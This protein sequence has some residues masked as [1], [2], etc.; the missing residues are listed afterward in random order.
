MIAVR[1]VADLA[2][3]PQGD[4]LPGSD[5]AGPIGCVIVVW[6][7]IW[8][9]ERIIGAWGAKAVDRL[10]RFVALSIGLHVFLA[11]FTYKLWDDYIRSRARSLDR[12]RYTDLV[13][14][15]AS[16]QRA[17]VAG[18]SGRRNRRPRVTT[19]PPGLAT[20]RPESASSAGHGRIRH[21]TSA[22]WS[23]LRRPGFLRPERPGSCN[24]ASRA[25]LTL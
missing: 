4:G 5:A 21:K 8:A 25:H 3:R 24:P 9:T 1:K 16:H 13:G 18:S 2:C 20:G 17:P 12:N 19:G 15:A 11:P 23:H 7:R 6:L 14:S 10:L 22:T